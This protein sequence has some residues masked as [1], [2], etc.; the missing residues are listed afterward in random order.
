MLRPF[1]QELVREIEITRRAAADRA[2]QHQQAKRDA[3]R[4]ARGRM[5]MAL[6]ARLRGLADRLEAGRGIERAATEP[7]SGPC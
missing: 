7:A 2:T 1:S 6:A 5:S 3:P 4:S